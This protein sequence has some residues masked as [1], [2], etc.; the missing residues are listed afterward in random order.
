MLIKTFEEQVKKRPGKIAVKAGEY[1]LTYGFLHRLS[2][3]LAYVI[4]ETG[5]TPGKENAAALLLGHDE[6]MIVGIIGALKAGMVYIPFDPTYPEERLA[7]MLKD[8]NVGLLVTNN[9]N[10]NLANKLSNHVK[11]PIAIINLD[12]IDAQTPEPDAH[13]RRAPHQAAYILYTSG[14]T[15]KPKGVV[16]TL[17]NIFYYINNWVKRFSVS[18][19]DRMALF[20]SF[21][22]DG[23]VP[24]IYGSL[25]SGATLYPFDVKQRA[26]IEEPSQWLTRE[27]ITIWH[28]VPTWYRY[29]V[30]TLTGNHTFPE[31]RLIVLGG[32]PVREHDIIMFKKYFP[33]SKF[34]NIY[35]QTETTVSSIWLLSQDDDFHKV[36]IGE[37]IDGT[38]IVV[39]D[40]EG[41]E[42]EELEVGEIVM[43]GHFLSPGYLNNAGATHNVFSR[44]EELERLYWSG[45]LGRLLPGGEIEIIGRKDL[46]VKVRGFRIEPGEI[47]TLLLQHPD[48]SEAVVAAKESSGGS[49]Y[50]TVSGD[51]HLWAYFVSPKDFKVSRLREYLARKLPDYMI[52]TSFVKLETMPLTPNGK[53]DRKSLDAHGTRLGTGTEYAPPGSEVEKV[54]TGIWKEVLKLDRI[55][56]DDNF[57][58]LGGNS[59]DVISLNNELQKTFKRN[60]PV[61]AIFRYLTVR[62]FARYLNREDV[63]GRGLEKKADRLPEPGKPQISTG[64][65]ERT[66]E[67]G[68]ETRAVGLEIAVIGMDGRFPGAKNIEEFWENLKNGIETIAFF[69]DE[70]LE[71][72]G[73]SLELLQN[74]GYVKAQPCVEDIEY[75]DASFFDYTPKE[76]EIM[77]PQMRIFHECAYHALEDAG[78]D[79]YSHQTIIGLYA[80]ASVSFH[81][82]TIAFL[83]SD[84][85]AAG[86]F[87]A[88]QLFDKEYLCSRVSHKL[89]L[90]GPVFS[91]QTACSTSLV[92]IHLACQGLINSECD[93]ALAGG[94]SIPNLKKEGY[95]SR[96][97]TIFSSDGHCKVFDARADGTV[98]GNGIGVVVLK[99]LHQAIAHGDH[100]YAVIRGSFIN[101]D[102]INRGGFTAPSAEGEA[103]VI[104]TALQL[105]KVE[106]ES[107]GYIETHSTGTPLGGPIEVEGLKLAFNTHKKGFCALGCVK[108]NVGHLNIAAGVTGFIKTVLIL[109]HGLIP[110]NLHFKTPDPAIDFENTPFYVNTKLTEWKRRAY[111][112]RAGVSSFGIGGTNVHVVLEEAPQYVTRHPSLVT[113]ETS[114]EREYH[115]ILLSARTASALERMTKNLAEFL[116]KNRDIDLADVSYTLTVGRK[117]WEHRRMLVCHHVDE[118]IEKL[119]SARP[120][121]VH[122]SFTKDK[123]NPVIFMFSGLGS[124]YVNMGRELYQTE[125]VFREE[126]DR[127][128]EILK[129][130]MG[131][132]PKE[133]LYPSDR[134]DRSDRSDQSDILINQIEIAPP[135]VFIFEYALAKLVMKWGITPYA[136]IGYSFGEYTAACISGVLSLADALKLIVSRGESIKKIPPGAMLSV[137]LPRDELKPLLNPHPELSLAIDNG[138]SCIAAGPGEA[139]TAFEKEMKEKKY[140]CMRIP[141]ARALHSQMMEPILEEFAG[142]TAKMITVNEPQIPYISNVTGSWITSRELTPAYWAKHLR[143]TVRFSDGINQLMKEE[144]AIFLEIGPGRDLSTLLVR[145]IEGKPGL[146]TTHLVKPQEQKTAD[147]Y[148]LLNRLGRLWLWGVEIDW[149]QFY[150]R[151]KRYRVCLPK[152]SFEPR[153]FPIEGN[154]EEKAAAIFSQHGPPEERQQQFTSNSLE[155]SPVTQ[156]ISQRPG[157]ETE[158][159]SPGKGNEME[160]KLAHIWAQFFGFECIGID[161]DFFD[162]GGDSLKAVIV[163]NKIHQELDIELA[164]NEFFQGPTIRK[165]ASLTA[166]KARE[167]Q[168]ET[169]QPPQVDRAEREEDLV[170]Y[171][172]QPFFLFN[173]PGQKKLFCFPS[174]L[175][176]GMAYK[177]LAAAITGYTFYSFNF[178]EPGDRLKRYVEIITGCQPVGPYILFGFSDGGKLTFEVAMALEKDGYQVSDIILVDTFWAGETS[179]REISEAGINHL[180]KILEERGVHFLKDKIIA[181][182]K[183]YRAYV[184]NRTPLEP[185][186]ANLHLIVS[187]ENWGNP[188]CKCWDPF[189][190]R[191]ARIYRG[192]GGHADMLYALAEKNGK[193]IREILDKISQTGGI[194]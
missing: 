53:I 172:D 75:F 76:A 41:D 84:R 143:E 9:E 48:I 29:F 18:D 96:K 70:E 190:A 185:V 82:Q 20:A 62:S 101:N 77:D 166:E 132:D 115:L 36:L 163:I 187:E 158:Y 81:W 38:E 125:P 109:E 67:I 72:A 83:T 7:Y 102:G 149:N 114:K 127:C 90:R 182:V 151:E 145:H 119:S 178:I 126:M 135:L 63:R 146:K 194:K 6:N 33:Y 122:S 121:K 54:L 113:G 50:S 8:S 86:L 15:G 64:E 60:I 152:Y 92:A 87:E 37:S 128:F 107:V 19:R 169:N 94:V 136:M 177:D 170:Q 2:S 175:A 69:S 31:L 4:T 71:E 22:H 179:T 112:R 98:F 129:P 103:L 181:K 51:H 13:I 23:A 58:D 32:E 188:L 117:A 161:D 100:I 120:G 80:G 150:S 153:A 140:I 91:L 167:K 44:D 110:P 155:E 154:L 168:V 24:D 25:L 68:Q 131:Y 42:V 30:N 176:F 137:P 52:P 89:D 186:N 180:V 57:F 164:M 73:I 108:T 189:T 5:K 141:S 118:A 142:K 111:P 47:E 88:R 139:V 160:Q 173:R 1:A 28:S 156:V 184:F 34:G 106:P 43:A 3:Q 61:V 138:P 46:Q 99:R 134:S 191:P 10:L 21:C 133:I 49:T 95:L 12:E 93:L 148:V 157:L 97:E 55:G 165:L 104:R 35:G 26:N 17:Q 192:Y 16:Q 124:Q 130:L 45:D 56:I 105:A 74:P 14:S 40:K 11:K 59:M 162:L 65:K 78:Y 123:D 159:V 147:N 171:F 174:A 144:K 66:G 39:V 183:S 193:I 116:K 85:S 79:P 27:N